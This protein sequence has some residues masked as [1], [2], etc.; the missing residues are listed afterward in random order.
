MD[1]YVWGPRLD[2][3]S[4]LGTGLG[5]ELVPCLFLGEPFVVLVLHILWCSTVDPLRVWEFCDIL[6]VPSVASLMGV[7]SE[8]APCQIVSEELRVPLLGPQW[9]LGP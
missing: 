9:Y 7:A 6:W 2:S 3:R 8:C 5:D 4:E 1:G